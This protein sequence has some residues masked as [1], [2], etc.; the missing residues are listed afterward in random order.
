MGE[1]EDD[2]LVGALLELAKVEV[3]AHLVYPLRDPH[4]VHLALEPSL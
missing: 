2:A 4:D 3:H 1:I